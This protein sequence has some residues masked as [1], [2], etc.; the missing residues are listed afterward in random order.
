MMKK[1]INNYNDKNKLSTIDSLCSIC[2]IFKYSH[3]KHCII[4]DK[5]VDNW[6][7]HC[8]WLGRCI[9]KA[10]A[11]YFNVFILN[12]LLNL[13]FNSLFIIGLI[14]SN[15]CHKYI[16]IVLIL[17]LIP[18]LGAFIAVIG[19]IKNIIDDYRIIKK[20]KKD[21]KIIELLS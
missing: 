13:I 18:F 11:K 12:I 3:T 6:D 9:C 4:C 21:P 14:S 16:K 19:T 15:K 1:A 8:F 20:E 2:H 17:M 5:C 10:N 7:H